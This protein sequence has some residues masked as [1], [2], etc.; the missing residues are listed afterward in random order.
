MSQE[1]LS[2][3]TLDQLRAL[4]REEILRLS[5]TDAN[6]RRRGPLEDFP[7]DSYGPWPTDLSLRRE[8][9]YTDDGR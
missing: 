2:D 1:R 6:E 4:I 3:L 9:I 8:D 5:D 7:V